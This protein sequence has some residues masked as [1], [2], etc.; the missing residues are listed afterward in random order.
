MALST[1]GGQGVDLRRLVRLLG[2]LDTWILEDSKD[3]KDSPRIQVCVLL[4][5]PFRHRYPKTTLEALPQIHAHMM[6]F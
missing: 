5:L 6:Q 4:Q 3:S 1:R 2:Y